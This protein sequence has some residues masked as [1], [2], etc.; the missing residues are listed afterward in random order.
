MDRIWLDRYAPGVPRD[1]DPN[2]FPSLV[3]IF[4]QSCATFADRPA[5]ACLGMRMSFRELDARSRAFAGFLQGLD[6]LGKGDRVALMMPNLLQY[7]VALFGTLR[8]G[9]TVVNVNPL[10]TPRELRHQ[11]Q[12]SGARVIVI[13]ANFAHVL[14]EVLA[15]TPVE[16]VVVTEVGDM[17]PWPRRTLVNLAVRYLKRMVPAYNLPG[18]RAF[19]QVLAEGERSPFTPV[20]V[21][22]DDLAFLQYTGGTTGVAKGAMLSHRN[23]VANVEQISCWVRSVIEDGEEVIITAL[24]LYHI[25]CLTVNCLTFMRHGGLNVLVINPRD[26][27]GFIKELGKWRFTAISGVNTLFNALVNQPDFARLDFSALKLAVGGGMMVQQV[28][29]ERWQS[30]TGVHLLEGYGLTEASPVVTINPTDLS[31]WSGS[32]GLPV[33]STDVEIRSDDG[34]EVE[35]GTP[36]ELCV[37]GPQVMEGYWQRP[38]ETARTLDEDGWLLTG[39]IARM[40][41]D[42]MLYIVDRKKDMIL[43]SG[44][45][46]Y[47]NE[48]ENVVAM[49]P[50]VVEVACIGVPDEKSG[51]AVKVFIVARE[52]AGLTAEKVREFCKANMTAYKVPRHVEFR[53]EL[54]KSNV[55]KILR[56]ALRDG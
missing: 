27:P 23:M 50:G 7:P 1:I 49:C 11:L 16:H 32:I 8:A 12:D 45:N 26:I 52:D 31:A 55:G 24:P 2:R 43:V 20:D 41:A 53:T 13:V 51:E 14:D 37:R 29:A 25:F 28:V 18:A 10:Y 33:P 54:P 17:L 6:G 5:F 21:G 40:D 48:V 4:E 39:D 30:L 46:V 44:F 38:E 19:R 42:G 35:P 15:D 22:G 56:R 47:P 9:M 34:A 3:H 36:G